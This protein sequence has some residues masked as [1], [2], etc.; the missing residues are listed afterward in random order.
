MITR[1]TLLACLLCAGV[2]GAAQAQSWPAK[3]LK[4]ISPYSPGGL[5]DLVPRGIASGLGERLGQQVIVENRPG[6]SQII[7][8]QAGELFKSLARVDMLHVPY[9]GAGPAMIDVM[10]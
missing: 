6:A 1:S 10:A 9:K 2:T 3:P 5:G 8:M 7:G 4:I